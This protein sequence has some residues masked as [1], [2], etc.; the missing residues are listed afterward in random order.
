MEREKP[1]SIIL[2]ESV[3]NTLIQEFGLFQYKSQSK[4]YIKDLVKEMLKVW[5]EHN[6]HN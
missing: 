1:K 6:E 2:P 3:Y 5:K 4:I